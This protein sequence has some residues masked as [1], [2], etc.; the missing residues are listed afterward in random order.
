MPILF[1][2]IIKI[3]VLVLGVDAFIRVEGQITRTPAVGLVL[4]LD[5]G[6]FIHEDGVQQRNP[7][8]HPLLSCEFL[9]F[10]VWCVAV[11][12]QDRVN[13]FCPLRSFRFP[14]LVVFTEKVE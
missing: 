12:K 11:L 8:A 13:V 10:V 5:T 2:V 14:K 1:V 3:L 7:V 9:F 4:V 6:A